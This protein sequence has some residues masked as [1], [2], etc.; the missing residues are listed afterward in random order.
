MEQVQDI[1]NA[2]SKVTGG[3]V[4][5]DLWRKSSEV[6]DKATELRAQ[7]SLKTPDAIHLAAA[8]V[9]G[10]DVFLTNDLRLNRVSV[11]ISIEVPQL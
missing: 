10:C 8:L 4:P 2:N 7:Y 1:S 6:F 11:K 9:S 3:I 5:I